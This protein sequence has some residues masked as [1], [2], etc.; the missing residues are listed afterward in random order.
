MEMPEGFKRT[1]ETKV[2][3]L[4]KS[5]YGHKQASRQWNLKLTSVLLATGF[6]QSARDYSRFT[7]KRDK[8]L[9]IVLVY[10]D[11]LLITGNNEQMITRAKDNLHD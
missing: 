6:T 5:L 2:C 1:E 11:N 8:D 9:V 10:I 4:L 3:N 7:L